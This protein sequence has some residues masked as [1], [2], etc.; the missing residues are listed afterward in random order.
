MTVDP[1]QDGGP[2]LERGQIAQLV[3]RRTEKPKP[4]FSTI[5]HQRRKSSTEQGL[6]TFLVSTI[7]R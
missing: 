5:F 2:T 7:I 4:P 3:E 1:D 6:A